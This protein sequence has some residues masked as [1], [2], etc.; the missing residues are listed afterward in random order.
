FVIMALLY[1]RASRK[2]SD[3]ELTPAQV[4]HARAYVGPHLLSAGV[5]GLSIL[6]A[7]TA[8]DNLRGAAGLL[9]FLMAPVQ[10]GYGMWTGRR[11]ARLLLQH[12]AECRCADGAAQGVGPA[13]GADAAGPQRR[14]TATGEA[15]LERFHDVVANGFSCPSGPVV[16]GLKAGAAA[17]RKTIW[18]G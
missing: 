3:L 18:R 5:G 2:R 9:Y 6:W 1:D 17:N 12:D 14:A 16:P 4:F 10:T 11:R 15:L 8:P 13:A 7:L